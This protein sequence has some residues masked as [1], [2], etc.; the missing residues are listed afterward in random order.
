VSGEIVL[1]KLIDTLMCTAIEHAGAERGLLILPRGV[2]QRI[3]AEAITSGDSII[4][5]LPEASMADVLLP[6]SIVHY[7]AR[8]QESVILDD[9]SAR[10]PFSTDSY[11]P[12]HRARSILC[13]PLIN[14]A[15]LIGVL[16]LENNLASHVFTPTRIAV[17]KLIASQ[18]AISL[19]NT[20]LYRDLEE[21]EGRIRRVVDANIM[22]IFIW[23]LSAVR[24]S[25]A[26]ELAVKISSRVV[27]TGG[28]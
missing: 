11:I 23:N 17:L 10:N 5:R 6:E 16:Y 4:V 28:T 26:K 15:K 20:R 22:G 13:L 8:T 2:E 27:C 21:R 24:T 7:V 3:E 14:Q 25:S 12:R 9:A 19:E 18:A 1:E